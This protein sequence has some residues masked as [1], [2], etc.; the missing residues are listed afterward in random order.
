[1]RAY[2]QEDYEMIKIWTQKNGQPV[3]YPQMLPQTGY[4][5]DNICAGFLYQTDSSICIIE[6]IVVNPDVD[7]EI[8]NKALNELIECLILEAK[9]MNY[10]T[11]IAFSDMGAVIERSKNFDFEITDNKYTMMSREI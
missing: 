3:P 11:I 4:I 7:K 10:Q 1:M 9:S 2:T 6:H 5:E 8:R